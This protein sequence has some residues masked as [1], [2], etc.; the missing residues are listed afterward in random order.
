MSKLDGFA[1]HDWVGYG[2]GYG[3][4]DSGSV[5]FMPS[6]LAILAVLLDRR[7][8]YE[9]AATMSGIAATP[10]ARM[11]FPEINTAITHL[12]DVLG[13][14]AYESMA[15][16][17]E[18]MTNAAM[19]TYALE[20]IDGA[21]AELNAVSKTTFETGLACQVAPM[22]EESVASPPG[23]L[24]VFDPHLVESSP[25]PSVRRQRLLCDS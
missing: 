11:S 12:R 25:Y 7:G 22:N 2:P 4:Y 6:A 20:Q 9:P 16:V 10:V 24:L 21:R 8:H 18:N 14:E 3:Y 17:G 15:R 5:S 23:R 19:A 1:L 13:D